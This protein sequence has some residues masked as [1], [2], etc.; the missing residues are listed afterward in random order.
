MNLWFSAHACEA[1]GSPSAHRCACAGIHLS[2]NFTWN[3]Q[4]AR[5]PVPHPT[6]RTKYPVQS[7]PPSSSQNFRRFARQLSPVTRRIVGLWNEWPT[8][9]DKPDRHLHC[10]YLD[11]P[12]LHSPFDGSSGTYPLVINRR[13]ID[14]TSRPENKS[15][16][17]HVKHAAR[18]PPTAPPIKP[19]SS[20]ARGRFRSRADSARVPPP[21][22]PAQTRQSPA[23]SRSRISVAQPARSARSAASPHP[24]RA[25]R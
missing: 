7:H 20:P 4:P 3:I 1:S 14:I 5:S 9:N 8:P 2:G 24:S 25:T 15:G 13:H 6:P 23:H 12:P 17:F 16:V 21:A 11:P 10:G 22:L 18:F 19:F